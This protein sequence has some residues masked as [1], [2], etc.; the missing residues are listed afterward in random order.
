MMIII[1]LAILTIAIAKER[2]VITHFGRMQK[3]K[4]M[5]VFTLDILLKMIKIII[6]KVRCSSS[7]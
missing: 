3:L 4:H 5:Q 6:L 7:P 1:F 2:N